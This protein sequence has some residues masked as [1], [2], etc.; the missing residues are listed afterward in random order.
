ANADRLIGSLN[1]ARDDGAVDYRLHDTFNTTAVAAIVETDRATIAMLGDAAALLQPVD[2]PARLLTRLQTEAAERLRDDI[3]R[4]D[5]SVFG[6]PDGACGGAKPAL[7]QRQSGDRGGELGRVVAD[8][9]PLAEQIA[10]EAR[11]GP[12]LVGDRTQLD[13]ARPD[14]GV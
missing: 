5:G 14:R 10:P 11:L 7:I 6:R 3:L 1:V 2:G 13:R 12:G 9:A 4:D 8:E